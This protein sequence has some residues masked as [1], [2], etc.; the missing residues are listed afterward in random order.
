MKTHCGLAIA[1]SAVMAAPLLAANPFTPGNLVVVRPAS[2][3][4]N[5]N[6]V[7]AALE[8]YTTTGAFVQSVPLPTTVNGANRRLTLSGNHA[9]DG[10][11]GLLSR[12]ADGRFL[13]MAGYDA[14][15]SAAFLSASRVV[16]RIDQNANIDTTTAVNN[17]Y[18]NFGFISG[19][20]SDDGSRFWLTGSVGN[21]DP[22]NGIRY[23]PLGATT[24]VR[25]TGTP[26]SA[27]SAQVY[28]GQLYASS[29]VPFFRGV[30]SVGTGLPTTTGQITTNLPGMTGSLPSKATDFFFAS[31]DLLY[32]CD[33]RIPTSG[34]G[35]QRW[36][37]NA[38]TWSLDYAL[39]LGS[40]RGCYGMTGEVDPLTELTTLYATTAGNTGSLVN[41]KLLAIT[42]TGASA[43]YSELASA[44]PVNPPTGSAFL[45]VA[46][47][48][49]PEPGTL[50]FLAL[51]ALTVVR[52][53]KRS[54]KGKRGLK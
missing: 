53:R 51:A 21:S 14:A 17:A 49:V 39:S 10:P 7:A 23:A 34:G 52:P 11:G 22:S 3:G 46:F 6:A 35:I 20:T 2:F 32:V 18:T 31:P 41:N 50:T 16:G 4:S 13:V 5:G 45:G 36:E 38:G 12:S 25:L 24:S 37:R 8:E 54:A 47:I 40:D 27:A 26:P 44:L 30:N 42:D 1:L 29:N 48:P 9:A 19:A 43:L 33:S 15:P 28:D